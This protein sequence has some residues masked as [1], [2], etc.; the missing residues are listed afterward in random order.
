MRKDKGFTLIELM[1]VVAI[2]AI[3]AAI[4]IPNLLRS[5]MAANESVTIGSLKTVATQEAIFRQQC[6]V[7]QDGNGAGEYGLLG[8]L[9]AEICVRY[10]NGGTDPARVVNPAY[11]SQQFRTAGSAGQ[12]YAIKSGYHVMMYLCATADA[13]TQAAS[14]AG[15]DKDL[16]GTASAGAA[17]LDPTVANQMAAISLQEICFA[18]YAW[19]AELRSTGGRA[20]FIN[21]MGEV[22]ATSMQAKTY[23]VSAGPAVNA[24]F[25]NADNVFKARISAGR[26][27]GVD[28][29]VWNPAQ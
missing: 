11:L 23:D 15:N 24:A 1:I 29:N 20:F 18:A 6:G 3:I 2:I 9:A 27:V 13:T 7:D 8:E 17:G 21:E 25:T 4:A 12:G 26:T 16:G 22:Y 14:S 19:P 10:P 28:G 5:R